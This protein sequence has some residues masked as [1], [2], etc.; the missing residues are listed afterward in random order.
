VAHEEDRL[1]RT[2]DEIVGDRYAESNRRT[3]EL[4]GVDLAAYGWTT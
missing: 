2:V 1:R 4:I 3:G